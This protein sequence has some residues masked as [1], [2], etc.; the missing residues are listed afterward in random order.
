M[1]KDLQTVVEEFR[2]YT[3]RMKDYTEAIGL[4]AWDLR[5]GAPKKGQ[6]QRSEVIGTLSADL[7]KMG[8]SAEMKEFLD[9]L[10]EPDTYE[11]LDP[12]TRGVVRE[13]KKE[14]ERSQRIP[15]ELYQEYVVLVSKSE[16]VWE[17]ARNQND[18]ASFRPYLEKILEYL[19]RFIEIWGYQGH[20]YNAL[21]DHYEP[22]ITVD[23]LDPLFADLRGKSIEL[24]HA[25]R[26]RGRATD[27][28]FFQKRFPTVD[29][30]R[31]S[32]H[33]LQKIGYDFEAGR[34]D[35]SAHP[36]ATGLN[37]GDVRVTTRF[38]ENDFR[39]AIFGAIH[40]AGHAMYEQNIS[41]DLIGTPLCDGASMGIHE[42]QSRFW[43]NMIG[44]SREFWRYFYHDLTAFFPEPLQGV[45]VDDFYR[46]VNQVEPSLIRVEADELTYNLHIM[47]RYDLEKALIC[48]DLS[49]SEL[50]VAWNE[51]MREYLGVEAPNDADGVMQDV[52]WSAGLF[53]YFPSYSLGNIYA[54][55]FEAALRR[56]LPDYKEAVKRGEFSVIKQWLR[57]NIHKHGK[58]L[59][60]REILVQATGES[61]D[62]RYLV[63]YLQEKYQSV[64]EL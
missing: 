9:R 30:R 32:E 46:A 16:T 63:N 54:A 17:T 39:T 59:E 47:L 48:G 5:T 19:D 8:V 12:I 40:E 62:V 18:F 53:G 25:I 44:R 20:K 57:D 23:I 24:L 7:F 28:S 13:C 43:E 58:L 42:S 31:F 64:Y 6:E 33:V 26:E 56:D 11:Q 10:S 49:V 41:P 14:Y 4:L 60:P 50:P 1:A 38:Q 34:L 15:A 21:L 27:T 45:S 61:I 3:R 2:R 29:Q 35:E 37:P 22:G 52:H 55:Q 36:F 51:K